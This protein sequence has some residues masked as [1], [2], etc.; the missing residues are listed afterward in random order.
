M[1]IHFFVFC[2]FIAVAFASGSNYMN[3]LCNYQSL[4][5]SNY[6]F[7]LVRWNN[8]FALYLDTL[9]EKEN[10]SS[11][12]KSNIIKYFGKISKSIEKSKNNSPKSIFKQFRCT[13]IGFWVSWSRFPQVLWEDWKTAF[14]WKIRAD[15]SSRFV[16]I[17]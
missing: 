11:N 4:I 16:R 2:C 13:G 5:N 8:E 9:T 15:F 17:S 6:I 3:E 14:E 7:L 12:L 10:L 1:K